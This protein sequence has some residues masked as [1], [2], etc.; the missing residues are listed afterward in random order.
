MDAN[1]LVV[2][3]GAALADL[4]A[5]EDTVQIGDEAPKP[6]SKDEDTNPAPPQKLLSATAQQIRE[7][8]R[9]DETSGK[10]VVGDRF[11]AVLKNPDF[12]VPH[13]DGLQ[14]KITSFDVDTTRPAAAH[15]QLVV[16]VTANFEIIDLPPGA[17]ATYPWKRGPAPPETMT[18]LYDPTAKKG[19]EWGEQKSSDVGQ[20]LAVLKKNGDSW[21]LAGTAPTVRLEHSAIRIDEVH[22]R[23]TTDGKNY[24][25]VLFVTPTAIYG[26]QAGF[27]ALDQ[28]VDFKLNTK[29]RISFS[30]KRDKG[31][32]AR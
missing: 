24:Q 28:W 18:F 7:E 21:D 20:I 3:I 12:R 25:I 22:S 11:A 30:T 14:V 27:M 13:A 6:I 8:L 9:Y 17:D 2:E 5:G 31:P 32:G 15:G 10:V 29:A 4:R 19:E 1:D 23:P 16:K 26:T